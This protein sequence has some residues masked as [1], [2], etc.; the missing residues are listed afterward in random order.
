[1]F[2]G[3]T[4]ITGFQLRRHRRKISG[5]RNLSVFDS[6]NTRS[7]LNDLHTYHLPTPADG[8]PTGRKKN[9]VKVDHHSEKNAV[10]TN[11]RYPEMGEKDNFIL[12]SDVLHV[13]VFK[14]NDS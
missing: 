8:S 5:L 9:S 12:R 1:M 3:T 14:T 6:G 11:G 10:G 13:G 4:N 2:Q 7:T